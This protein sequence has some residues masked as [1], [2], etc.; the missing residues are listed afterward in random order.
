[1]R[2][3]PREKPGFGAVQ[4]PV[5]LL[6]LRG[7]AESERLSTIVRAAQGGD[8]PAIHMLVS[9]LTPPLL[10]TVRAL[11]GPRHPDIE[12]L[13]QD[14]LLAVIDA[15]PSFCGGCTRARLSADGHLY[16]CLFASA[17]TDLR[18]VL[19][20]GSDDSAVRDVIEATWRNRSDRYSEMRFVTGPTER[21]EMSFIGG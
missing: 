4:V 8:P 11:M 1:M 19:R 21:V 10:Q 2:R 12:D 7:V 14:V 17:G 3:D 6:G 9:G 20:G 5:P 16:T 13:A 18:P 15:L